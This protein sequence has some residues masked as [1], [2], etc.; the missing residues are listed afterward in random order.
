MSNDQLGD[1]RIECRQSE[2]RYRKHS[3]E[4]VG[5]DTRGAP[6]VGQKRIW[7]ALL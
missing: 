1:Q 7:K 4:G 3:K 2:R 6:M 5:K